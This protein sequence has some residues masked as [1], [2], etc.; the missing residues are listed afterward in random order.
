MF[1]DVDIGY[2]YLLKI[3]IKEDN[4]ARQICPKTPSISSCQG[5]LACQSMVMFLKDEYD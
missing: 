4:R 1:S 5:K 3:V 2:S